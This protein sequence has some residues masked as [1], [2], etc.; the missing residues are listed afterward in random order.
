VINSAGPR[1]RGSDTR[2]VLRR[3]REVW[4]HDLGHDERAAILAWAAFTGTFGVVRALTHWIKA[5]HGPAGGGLSLG[6][7][8]FHHFN[9]GIGMLS[10]LGALLVRDEASA[11]IRSLPVVPLAY[12]VANALIADEA[13]L[14]LDLQDVYWRPQ[15]RTSVDIAV[16][17]IGVGGLAL[18]FAPL[19]EHYRRREAAD[20]SV[21]T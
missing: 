12:G 1:A 7:E 4:L 11:S 19:I 6:G 15:G 20:H 9:L 5:G 18:A 16:G 17:A 3:L 13:A 8:H 14:L 2:A 10:G 21:S